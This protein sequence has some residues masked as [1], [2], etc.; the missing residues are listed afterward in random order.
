MEA[1][2]PQKNS[3]KSIPKIK[4]PMERSVKNRIGFYVILV[5]GMIM[6]F[7]AF[8]VANLFVQQILT[9]ENERAR[10]AATK[11]IQSDFQKLEND[12]N[13][14]SIL[15][16]ASGANESVTDEI[17]R[18]SNF[19]PLAKSLDE[20]I[21]YGVYY[22]DSQFSKGSFAQIYQ[23]QFS[24]SSL[25]KVVDQGHNLSR[26][27]IL[28]EGLK[29]IYKY[30]S[31][32]ASQDHFMF[33]VDRDL[34]KARRINESPEIFAKDLLWAKPV[35]NDRKVLEGYIFAIVNAS[36]QGLFSELAE[37]KNIAN[38]SVIN[39]D[40]GV[41]LYSWKN[42]DL[43][44]AGTGGIPVM[45]LEIKMANTT[46][47][48][49]GNLVSTQQRDLLI[50][51]PWA[52]LA[53]IG[54][55]V[56]LILLHLTRSEKNATSLAKVNLM[57]EHKNLQLGNEIHER[58][59]L[60][61]VLRKAERENKAIINAISDVIF[62]ISLNG[63]I[64]FLNEAWFKITGLA[65]QQVLGAN[66]FDYL[67]PKDQQ[68]QKKSVSQMIKGLRGGYRVMTSI[69]TRDNKF[70]A[71]EMAVSMIRMDENRSMR[72]VG[73]FTD[74]EERQKAEWALMEAE[75]KYRS[76]WENAGH[77]IYQVKFEGGIISANPSIARIF[78][79]E[80]P[81]MMMREIKNAHLELF[82]DP[83]ERIKHLRNL[84]EDR[85]QDVLECQ[86]IRKNGEKFWVQETIRPVFD[87][88]D[89]L[90][91]F[92]GS[93]EDITKR[94][95]AEIQL[96]DAKRESDIA[97][98]AKSEFLANMSHELRT[99]LNSIIGFSE[100]IRN[101]VF[102]PVEPKSY[103]EYARDIHDSGKHLLSI[104]NQILDISRIDAGERDLRETRIDL[105]KVI[106]ST[107]DLMVPKIKE[108][109]LI[110]TEPDLSEFT[111]IIGEETAIR[112]MLTNI[113]SNAI[114]FTPE[115][116]HISLSGEVDSAGEL[117]I[118][119]TDT[120]IGL[121]DFEIE[122]VTSKFGTV[123]GRLNKSAYGLGLGLSLVHS[124]MRLHGGRVEI[125]SQKG[126]GTT[127]TL[128]FPRVRLE[129]AK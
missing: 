77:G 43:A 4:K 98:R 25:G 5:N 107:L 3:K 68:E 14:L 120:G 1:E 82:I 31:Y 110:L 27:D 128:V 32:I 129:Q 99:P 84:T 117:R 125:I 66:L 121:D 94:K 112:Q 106:K 38:F 83:N 89:N 81:E 114:K 44:P 78:G 96:H 26:E 17:K 72:V 109:A 13:I 69:K 55:I 115:G 24:A 54:G 127:V 95:D 35:Y 74:M 51:M 53:F 108:A 45:M 73:S 111:Y 79:F 30:A 36:H 93:V 88:R 80:T 42:K 100:I 85:I 2:K 103:W 59:R 104:I 92:E 9:E 11:V 37:F 76:I 58:E 86:G 122:R 34:M 119:V 57:L 56:G 46:S 21:L 91:Y 65:V 16:G 105:Q 67:H 47:I 102:G 40:S 8:I 126:I 63:T 71:V 118:S 64:L 60:N 87:E 123:D 12:L 15:L 113:I 48:I 20:G 10:V 39:K 28:N 124:L 101:E 116:G 22:I 50:F 23:H 7:V 75:R 41:V 33:I 61:N 70:R 6:M 19:P 97:N 52:A 18:I 29:T 49:T 90:I 62:E